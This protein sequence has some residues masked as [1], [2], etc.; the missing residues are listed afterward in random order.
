L[1]VRIT[2]ANEGNQPT[3]VSAYYYL[4]TLFDAEGTD[5]TE[6]EGG[7]AITYSGE[8]VLVRPGSSGT[9]TVSSGASEPLE[10]IASFEI[11][12]ACE[13]LTFEAEGAYCQ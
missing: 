10:E 12:I 4:M 2:I 6:G 7:G 9:L 1:A 11:T 8:G 5:I 13:S 3:D